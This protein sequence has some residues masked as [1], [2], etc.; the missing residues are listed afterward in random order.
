MNKE[1]RVIIVGVTAAT[2]LV[3]ALLWGLPTTILGAARP[4]LAAITAA[5]VV[6]WV[7]ETQI[8]HW[9]IFRR[10]LTKIPDLR[11]V[12]RVEIQ[13]TWIDPDTGNP[14]GPIEGFAQV[15]QTATNFCMRTFTEES[16]SKTVAYAFSFDQEVFK[17]AIVYENQPHISLREK[18][19]AYHQGSA[20]FHVR[21][22][23]PVSFSGEYWTERKSIGTFSVS[24]R[25]KGEID[26]FEA[27]RELFAK[28]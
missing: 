15:D 16:R 1:L 19:S 27:G 24:S 18:R 20:A 2:W 10:W 7:Y 4:F 3:A 6:L 14:I 28:P 8:W 25:K 22:Y 13:S 5:S 23:K 9:P 17:L 12:W 26:S 11:G 21:G